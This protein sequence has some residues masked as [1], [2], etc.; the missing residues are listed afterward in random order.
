MCSFIHT[1]IH[2]FI[3][4][5]L[6]EHLIC[7]KEKMTFQLKVPTLELNC[8][9]ISTLIPFNCVNHKEQLSHPNTP[10]CLSSIAPKTTLFIVTQ[11]PIWSAVDLWP[12][13]FVLPL[14][15]QGCGPEFFL[16]LQNTKFHF[17]GVLLLLTL[18]SRSLNHWLFL[19]IQATGR[20]FS[21]SHVNYSP[22][23]TLSHGNWLI[24]FKSLTL[25]NDSF[26]CLFN[27]IYLPWMDC[28]LCKRGILQ[29][30]V[31]ALP[32]VLKDCPVYSRHIVN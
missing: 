18:L 3:Q 29:T 20:P 24:Y 13:P 28:K 15:S 4:Q 19:N 32:F 17:Q 10:K 8:V 22:P 27:C 26:A 16:V 30:W 6:I 21:P 25:W 2:F 14:L 5:T 11:G 7:T 1:F 9:L 23:V 31:K 12:P